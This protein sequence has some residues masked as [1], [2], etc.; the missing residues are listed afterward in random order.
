MFSGGVF[1]LPLMAKEKHQDA[2]PVISQVEIELAGRKEKAEPLK[3]TAKNLI[4]F[5]EGKTLSGEILQDAIT[6]LKRS[7]LFQ[8]ISVPDPDPDASAVTLVFRLTPYT[9]IK[10]ITIKGGFP[11]LERH[12]LNAMTVYTGDVFL[13]EKIDR[14]KERIETLFTDEGYIDPEVTITSEQDPSDLNHHLTITID[15]GDYYVVRQIRFSGNNQLTTGRLQFRFD[16]WKTLFPW[17]GFKRFVRKKI[18]VQ[19]KSLTELYR[20]KGYADVVIKSDIRINPKTNEVDVDLMIDEG[21]LYKIIFEGNTCFWDFQLEKNLTLKKNGNPNDLSLKRSIRNIKDRYKEAGYPDA[22]VT[23]KEAPV[24]T[25]KNIRQIH[26]V[27][28][29]GLRHIV[30]SLSLS[31][32]RTVAGEEID[33]QILT[34]P[35]GFWGGGKFIRSVFEADKHSIEALYRKKGYMDCRITSAET[36]Q[37]K[38]KKGLRQGD[39]VISVEE[40]TQTLIDDVLF[41]GFYVLDKDEIRRVMM[42]KPGEPFS[43]ETLREDET[44]I[45]ALISEK[46]Y[47]HVSVAG[48]YKTTAD[49]K[50][51]TV[52]FT[53]EQGPFVFTGNVF[54]TG[55]FRTKEQIILN[56]V[57]NVPGTAFSLEKMLKTQQNIR[58]INALYSAGFK[59]SGFEKKTGTVH[60]LVTAEEKRPYYFEVGAGYDTKREAYGNIKAGDRNLFGLNKEISAAAEYSRIGHREELSLNEPRF[61]GTRVSA[62]LN[63]YNETREEFNLDYGTRT[64]GVSLL[65]IR[66]VLKNISTSLSFHYDNRYQYLLNPD[67]VNVYDDDQYDPRNLFTLTPSIIYDSTD[68]HI[69]PSK[70]LYTSFSTDISKGIENEFDDF[71]RHRLELRCFFSPVPGI[72]LAVRGKA[73]YLVPNKS[74]TQIP[75]DQL[76]FL[77]GTSD[78]RGFD[79]N[80]LRYDENRNPVGGR[81]TFSGTFE[82]RYTLWETLELT[83]F[84]DTGSIRSTYE[85]TRSE[86]FRSSAGLGLRYLTPIGPIGF[87]GGLKINPRQGESS[88]KVHF[89]IGHTF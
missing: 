74:N 9:R 29:E 81:R 77:G 84:F 79:E 50:K 48:T 70:G 35:A 18:E 54:A 66:R 27:I 28:S 45:A 4:F 14:Q 76:F 73:G 78:V 59:L 51:A 20:R 31:G 43:V 47:P 86:G 61:I 22:R 2:A 83:P 34:Q 88:G 33:K 87:I 23:L 15:K 42:S 17:A 55:N 1:P 85:N 80:M 58:N 32:N 71:Y 62:T 63:L 21:P 25:K 69:S 67:P 64:Y 36:W 10:N 16:A 82:I 44:E 11:V 89:T 3:T 6:I 24:N 60:L 26:L 37:D 57:E 5:L 13:P 49:G 53:A 39:I 68:S 19:V 12:I 40:G 30:R 41:K 75:E 72:T 56:E 8:A 38:A 65:F 7:G 52:T 46:G